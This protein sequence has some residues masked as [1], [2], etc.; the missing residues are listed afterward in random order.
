MCVRSV[1]VRVCAC[2]CGWVGGFQRC[3]PTAPAKDSKHGPTIMLLKGLQHNNP[4]T[5][6]LQ[7]CAVKDAGCIASQ[8]N[9]C[10][11]VPWGRLVIFARHTPTHTMYTCIHAHGHRHAHAH[12]HIHMPQTHRSPTPTPTHTHRRYTA[13]QHTRTLIAALCRNQDA[14]NCVAKATPTCASG[15]PT[16]LAALKVAALADRLIVDRHKC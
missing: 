16:A 14:G 1:C 9:A 5:H 8:S 6:T 12:T 7:R 10:L 3:N 11:S 4:H 15:P 2:V 13:T